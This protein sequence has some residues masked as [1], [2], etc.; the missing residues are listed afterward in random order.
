MF[1]KCIKILDKEKTE[2]FEVLITSEYQYSLCPSWKEKEEVIR[3]MNCNFNAHQ[4]AIRDI[5]RN[6]KKIIERLENEN[7]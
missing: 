4:K 6:Q 7:N 1:D 2:D 5:I 3:I